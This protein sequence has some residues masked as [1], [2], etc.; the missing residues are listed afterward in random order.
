V[1]KDDPGACVIV[2]GGGSG[3]SLVAPASASCVGRSKTEEPGLSNDADREF[4]DL[5]GCRVI[6]SR[7][8]NMAASLNQVKD[9]EAIEGLA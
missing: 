2:V 1:S 7:E 4:D 9:H 5:A 3:V 8:G 6:L